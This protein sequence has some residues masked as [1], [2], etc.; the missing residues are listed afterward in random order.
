MILNGKGYWCKVTGKPRPGYDKET[1]EW[2]F[3][4]A[5]DKDTV[6]E[7]RKSGLGKYVKNKDDERGDYIHLRRKAKKKNGDAAQPITIYNHRNELW[8]GSLIG[9]GSTLNVNVA[10][11]EFDKKLSL[12]P[13]S[14][15]VWDH[16]PY[17]PKSPFEAK[18]GEDVSDDEP[19]FDTEEKDPKD[20]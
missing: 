13:L 4:L 10:I 14:I 1:L 19:P 17:Q 6:K 3:D 8:D 2:S 20:W 5:I 9:N 15:Q 12:S 7:L 11:N 16:V 18:E